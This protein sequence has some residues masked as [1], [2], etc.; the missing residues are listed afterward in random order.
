DRPKSKL[1]DRDIIAQSVLF[2]IAGFGTTAATI[3]N[4]IYELAINPTVQDRLR[5]EMKEKLH[6]LKP[7]TEA[8]YE[9]VMTAIPYLDAVIK[10]TLR[11]YPPVVRIERRLVDKEYTLAG[12][13]LKQ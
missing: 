6:G 5:E 11:K 9:A 12:I 2:L 3:S 13:P 8:Y 10:E 1:S 4:I 7:N